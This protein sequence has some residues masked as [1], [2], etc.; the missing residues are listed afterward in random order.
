MPLWTG[1]S[2][3]GDHGPPKRRVLR[4]IMDDNVQKSCW[5]LTAK[6]VIGFAVFL[7]LA[8][9]VSGGAEK[10]AVVAG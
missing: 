3:D 7:V 4:H 8:W 1:C 6:A 2:V 9:L 10:A 5:G